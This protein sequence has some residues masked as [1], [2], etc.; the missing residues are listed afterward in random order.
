M[1]TL[2]NPAIGFIRHVGRTRIAATIRKLKHDADLLLAIPGLQN[3][4]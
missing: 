4:A 2:R 3:D 1:A